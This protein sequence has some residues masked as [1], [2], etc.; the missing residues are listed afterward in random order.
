MG[1]KEKGEYETITNVRKN[2]DED[3]EKICN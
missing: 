2:G 3:L 1:K